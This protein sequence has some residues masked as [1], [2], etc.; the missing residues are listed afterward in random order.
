M[1][2]EFEST[3]HRFV[4]YQMDKWVEEVAGISFSER[5]ALKQPLKTTKAKPEKLAKKVIREE[6]IEV[7]T[8]NTPTVTIIDPVE[9]LERQVESAIKA[10]QNIIKDSEEIKSSLKEPSFENFDRTIPEIN[11]IVGE[12]HNTIPNEVVDKI[13]KRSEERQDIVIDKNKDELPEIIEEKD[14]EQEIV[15]DEDDEEDELPEIIEEKDDEQE[16]VIDEDDDED[17]LPEIIEEKDV[18]QKIVI[19]KNKDEISALDISE[20]ARN[21]KFYKILQEKF[22][23]LPEMMQNNSVKGTVE[24]IEQDN[25]SESASIEELIDLK[26]PETHLDYL[27]VAAYYLK[28][29]DLLDR[30]SLKQINSKVIKF[31]Q[32]PINHAIIQEAVKNDFLEVVPDYTGM[33]DVTEYIITSEGINYLINAM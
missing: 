8:E 24:Q 3:D 2:L 17:E 11:G 20:K 6:D 7:I 4:S 19:N 27:I 13:S 22:A 10:T 33:A 5:P 18:E 1:S 25:C 21:N 15:I 23:S 9:E 32:K 31:I 28:E 14:V 12:I 26:N 29:I 30:Y 16:I